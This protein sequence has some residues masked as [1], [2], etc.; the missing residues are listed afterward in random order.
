[1]RKLVPIFTAGATMPDLGDLVATY[2]ASLATFL[3]LRQW[4]RVRNPLHL[5][6]EP[7][8]LPTEDPDADEG[9]EAGYFRVRVVNRGSSPLTIESF[10]VGFELDFRRMHDH[11]ANL[12]GTWEM[13]LGR[14]PFR[15]DTFESAE[16]FIA[17]DE[18]RDQLRGRPI[19]SR[20]TEEDDG[21][22][23]EGWEGDPPHQVATVWAEDIAGR[24][25]TKRLD[26][27]W[28]QFGFESYDSG[29]PPVVRG[30]LS[31]LWIGRIFDL[32]NHERLGRATP[33]LVNLLHRLHLYPTAVI[34]YDD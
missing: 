21:S 6:L 16:S 24:R 7:A 34:G 33:A 12:R 9:W 15:L 1:M 26:P 4:L 23:I 11:F 18:V 19:E 10:G 3:A 29:V 8:A 13:T 30:R 5:S 31:A 14:G 22:W 28:R 32:Y 27:T 20:R 17:Q 25:Y 2:G